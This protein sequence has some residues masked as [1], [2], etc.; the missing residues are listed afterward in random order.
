MIRRD[1]FGLKS[2]AVPKVH[3][4]AMAVHLAVC[5]SLGP[6]DCLRC[7]SQS[8]LRSPALSLL[9]SLSSAPAACLAACLSA[10]S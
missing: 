5:H 8:R 7:L 4:R 3:P 1:D 9:R 10:A 6:V 2:E